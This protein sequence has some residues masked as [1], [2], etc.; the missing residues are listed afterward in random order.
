MGWVDAMDVASELL[1]R[2]WKRRMAFTA[3][4]GFILFPATGAAVLNWWSTEKAKS[5][6]E[7]ILPAQDS[8]TPGAS[9]DRQTS[10]RP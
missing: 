9:V 8:P 5:I 6:I 3:I 10:I 1:S 2:R 7:K 4:A